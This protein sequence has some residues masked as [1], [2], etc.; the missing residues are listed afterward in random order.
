MTLPNFKKILYCGSGLHTNVIRHF[1]D[2][3]SFLFI[4]SLPKNEYGYDYYY[5]GFYRNDFILRLNEKLNKE[6]F[7]TYDRIIFTDNYTEINKDYLESTCIYFYNKYGKNLRSEKNLKYF[8]S[9][10]IPDDIYNNV[11]LQKEIYSCDT[12]IISGYNPDDYLIKYMN[13]PF[14]VIMYDSSYYPKDLKTFLEKDKE[15]ENTIISYILK[16]PSNILSYTCINDQGEYK[17]FSS[18]ED[19]YKYYKNDL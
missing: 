5:R 12:L 9:T 14:N 7:N 1:N 15:S 4:D 11:Y 17:V 3:K 8:I 6:G 16:Y 18:Y 10:S 2:V 19:F 13:K